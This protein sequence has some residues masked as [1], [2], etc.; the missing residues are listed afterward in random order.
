MIKKI[1]F[2]L[3]ILYADNLIG[4]TITLKDSVVK[5]LIVNASVTSKNIGETSDK[6]GTVN[7]S[8][9]IDWIST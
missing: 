7:L 9:V 6:N 1:L 2:L 8:R 4:Q 3:V 5:S